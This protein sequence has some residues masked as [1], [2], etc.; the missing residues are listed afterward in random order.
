MM[1]AVAAVVL[2]ATALAVSAD[3]Q[4][5]QRR[6][7]GRFGRNI[8]PI[9]NPNYDGAFMFCRIMFRNAS[10]ATAPAGRSTG[11]ARTRTSPSASPS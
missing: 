9:T 3:A 1:R 4:F 2:L 11:R 6:G 8:G 10:T 7:G 5:Q